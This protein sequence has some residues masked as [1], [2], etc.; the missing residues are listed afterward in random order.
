MENLKTNLLSVFAESTVRSLLNGNRT[1][2][3]KMALKLQ[4]KFNIPVEA[5]RDIKSFIA[6]SSQKSAN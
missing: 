3:L 4:E 1:P 6:K 5:W 2:S